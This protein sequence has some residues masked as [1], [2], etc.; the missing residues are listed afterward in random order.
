VS[1][2]RRELEA[3]LARIAADG[4]CADPATLAWEGLR[5]LTPPE[6]ISTTDCAATYR[7]IPNAEGGARLWSATM[8]PYIN[9]IQDAGDDATIPAIAV[10]G[11]ARSGKTM[12]AENLQFKR[13]KFGPVVDLLWYVPPALLDDYLDTTV[14]PLF[15]LHPDIAAKVGTGKSDNKRALKKLSGK[16]LQWLAAQP[17]KLVGKQAPFIVVDEIDIL[18][19]KLR[20]NI[21]QQVA[22]RQRAFG[23]MARAYFCSHP[24]AGWTDGIASIWSEGTRGVWFW[25]CPHC[26][27]WSSPCPTADWRMRLDFERPKGMADDELLDHVERTAGLVCPHC[28]A[29]ITN[30]HKAAMNAAGKWVHKGETI[31]LDGTVTGKPFANA[32]TTFWIHGTM[33]PLVTWGALAKELVGARLHFE[34]TG[35]SER[36]R[37]VTAKSLGEVYEGP[38]GRRVD[39]K[40]LTD[41]MKAGDEESPGRYVLG[42]V[43]PR[44]L[45]ITASVDVGGNKFDVAWI[46]WGLNG[47]SW[48]IDRQTLVA[49]PN[50]AKLQPPLIQDHWNVL[51]SQVLQRRFPIVGRPGWTLGVAIMTYDTNG[52][53]GTTAKAKEF[54]RRMKLDPASGENGYRVRPIYG[55]R[56]ATAPEIGTPKQLDRTDDGKPLLP[57]IHV[58]ALGVFE[59][60]KTVLDRM[61]IDAPG[62]GYMHFPADCPPSVAD[63]LLNEPL[64]DDE[65]VRRGPNE[66]LDLYAYGEAARLMLKPDRTEIDWNRP[67]PWARPEQQIVAQAATAAPAAPPLSPEQEKA[68]RR[69]ELLERIAR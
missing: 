24:D 59:L 51:K 3:D 41:R 43:P 48:L 52:A 69:R 8:F 53:P 27:H 54:A 45:F 12:A 62:P 56:K 17:A 68:R 58:T 31:A 63:E 25:P 23:N 7:L 55:D 67:P 42:T 10:V 1:R 38:S 16:F 34:R 2:I 60:K 15:E 57:P 64:I 11:P 35:K 29:V 5:L 44:V 50:G 49:A 28:G 36:L 21:R 61:A 47:E 6:R 22:F 9:G 4:F 14:A 37:E 13:M 39:L 19:K 65:F 32:T 40:Q 33:S 18:A 30:D 26:N 20:S 66:T 46:G